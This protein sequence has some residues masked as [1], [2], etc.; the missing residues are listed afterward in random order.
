[1]DEA[2]KTLAKP[3]TK[4]TAEGR[5]IVVFKDTEESGPA[6]FFVGWANN[7]DD[8]RRMAILELDKPDTVKVNAYLVQPLFA[9]VRV[10]V[11]G[12]GA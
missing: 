12:A 2:A 7:E 5:T 3:I 11:K 6:P 1:M 10:T 8:A 9:R 4:L